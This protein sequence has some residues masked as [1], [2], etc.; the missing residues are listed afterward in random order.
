MVCTAGD[1]SVQTGP[2]IDEGGW[3]FNPAYGFVV[4]D[5]ARAPC[6]ACDGRRTEQVGRAD[7]CKAGWLQ[8]DRPGGDLGRQRCV[9]EGPLQV[10]QRA[11]AQALA[12]ALGRH[13]L[14]GL[15]RRSQGGHPAALWEAV[16][17][18]GVHGQANSCV[19][20]RGQCNAVEQSRRT[21]DTTPTGRGGAGGTSTC[22]NKWRC[23]CSCFY[24]R[25][26]CACKRGRSSGQSG[27]QAR[28]R[29][30]AS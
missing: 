12:G 15:V 24:S 26:G 30:K 11:L 27:G 16:R 6:G 9:G 1:G 21:G 22:H 3:T 23:P 2:A 8:D 29:E 7:L 10:V 18:G 14:S 19:A 25:A 4:E 20:W 13:P 17:G 28:R 5:A